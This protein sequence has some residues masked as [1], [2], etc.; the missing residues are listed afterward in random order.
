MITC[1]ADHVGSLLRPS[2]LIAAREGAATG[3]VSPDQFKAVEDRAVE[4]AISLQESVGLP[5]ITD[6]EQRR[7]S[8][9][10]QFA[11][12]VEGLGAW[13]LNAFLWGDWHGDTAT[14]GNRTVFKY[15]EDKDVFQKFYSQIL[16]WCLAHK[17]LFLCVLLFCLAFS[18]RAL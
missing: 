11:E 9:Q 6:G 5:V 13:D 2:E 10:S 4:Q 14:V 12:S 1:H 8:F 3:R 7:L 17:V 15:I 18:L 16:E